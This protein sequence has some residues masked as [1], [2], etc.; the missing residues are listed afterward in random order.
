MGSISWSDSSSRR[1]GH[2]TPMGGEPGRQAMEP[3]RGQLRR[4]D[5]THRLLHDVAPVGRHGPVQPGPPDGHVLRAASQAG[6]EPPL[7]FV[8]VGGPDRQVRQAQ[9]DAII[10]GGGSVGLLEGGA[11]GLDRGG[12]RGQ[13]DVCP[14][15]L[16]GGLRR[17]FADRLEMIHRASRSRAGLL[18]PALDLVERREQDE[19]GRPIIAAIP[20]GLVNEPFGVGQPAGLLEEMHATPDRPLGERGAGYDL[21]PGFEGRLGSPPCQLA[22]P[23]EV[24]DPAGRVRLPGEEPPE[25]PAGGRVSARPSSPIRSHRGRAGIVDRSTRPIHPG[26]VPPRRARRAAARVNGGSRTSRRLLPRS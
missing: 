1:A 4:G 19:Q 17:P 18:D 3:G 24:A 12:P 15:H 8:V 23:E 11:D 13:L 2:V 10:V 22:G 5:A 7:G 16:N 25:V 6:V 14:K 26:A 20:G 21:H 9:P